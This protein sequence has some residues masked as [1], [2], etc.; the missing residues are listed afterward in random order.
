MIGVY[1]IE[2]VATKRMYVGK[3]V[4]VARRVRAHFAPSSAAVEPSR[5]HNAISKYGSGEFT[6]T[7]L[8]EC[9]TAEEA[10]EREIF[11]IRT[12]GTRSPKGFNL[13]D[14]GDGTAGL[15]RPGNNVGR[16]L[17]AETREKIRIGNTGKKISPETIAKRS[18]SIRGRV[19]AR[20][21]RP[22]SEAT[23]EKLSAAGRGR[24]HIDETRAKMRQ[25]WARR[26]EV[27]NG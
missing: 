9:A 12:L 1:V 7:V 22:V 10:S 14:G 4:D 8:E 18:A 6:S 13:T 5:L 20:N 16:V 11:W 23:R 3:S 24:K 26:K 19:P 27:D 21:L 2:H 15:K 25:A 17:S